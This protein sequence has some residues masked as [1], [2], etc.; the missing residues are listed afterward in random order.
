MLVLFNALFGDNEVDTGS[1]I[2]A[3]EPVLH[4]RAGRLHGRVGDVH[5]PRQH[6]ADP[7]RRGRA[8]AVAGH[9][10]AA[11]GVPRRADRLGDRARRRRRA[12]HAGA[13]RRRLRPRHRGGQGA[14]G[15]RRRSSSACRRSPRSG[16]AVAGLCP[17]ASAASAVANAIILPMAFISDIFIPIEDPPAWLAT[18]GDV[19]PLKPFA[20][21]FQDAFNPAVEPPAFALGRAGAGRRV[22]R[23][24]RSSL[25]CAGSGGS[26]PVA[27]RPRAGGRGRRPPSRPD[28][29]RSGERTM[30]PELTEEHE[31]L[32]AVVREFVDA[33]IEPHAEAW[34]R[35]H[36]F[37]VD[38]VLAMGELGPVRHPVPRALRRR[39]RPHRAVRRDRGDRP[40]RPVD[41]D[42]AGGRRRARRQPD[43][44][45]RHA[46]AAGA[47]AA[48][49]VRRAGARRVRADRAGRRQRRRRHAH[50]RP[51][52]TKAPAS[53]SIDGEKAFITNSGT[54]ITS[55]V[56]VTALTGPGEISMIV[57]PAG[58]PGFEVQPPYRK[59]GW[60]ASD[61]HG[62]TFVECRVPEDHLL[63]R[64][65][66]GS[67]S[68][69]R[70]STR[71][72]SPSPPSPSA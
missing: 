23:R 50:A 42:H 53:G 24:R 38:T 33:E 61:T 64:A 36:T 26:L 70:S 41:G 17:S 55:I 22:G 29:E 30:H 72:A 54:P 25:R 68:S 3:A 6:R 60:H 57:V 11:V 15:G 71:A 48:R 44:Q 7:P 21:S 8:Q 65:A 31:A 49:P 59:M 18:L 4:R 19:L 14:G 67:P 69:S 16:M 27:A 62:L 9:A 52:S 46:R 12:D 66:A 35:D 43:P 40:G 1:G 56:T 28:D 13:R 45:V 51:G 2:V 34:D 47:L 39:R 37:P 10:A 32:R 58:T 20:Q 5:Q 63:G